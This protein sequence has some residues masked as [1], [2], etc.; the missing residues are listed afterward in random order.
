MFLK[1]SCQQNVDIDKVMWTMHGNRIRARLYADFD[2]AAST[3]FEGRP[4]PILT[5]ISALRE[6]M[7]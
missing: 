5:P 1:T 2:S 6:L 3:V 4:T 7:N